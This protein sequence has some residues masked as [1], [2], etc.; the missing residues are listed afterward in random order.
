MLLGKGLFSITSTRPGSALRRR[1][2]TLLPNHHFELILASSDYGLRKPDERLFRVALEKAEL[3]PEEVWFCGD[4][5]DKDIEGARTA[6]IMAVLYQGQA[7][8]DILRQHVQKGTEWDTPI[9]A[10]WAAL[11]EILNM[12]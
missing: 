8:G 11:I 5:Y 1:I 10:D 7:D 9:I 4:T 12:K 6:G 2:D 3:K